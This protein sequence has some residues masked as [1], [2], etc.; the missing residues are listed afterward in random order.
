M[1]STAASLSASVA[2][3]RIEHDG[4]ARL[5]KHALDAAVLLLGNGGFERRQRARLARFEDRLGG[6]EPFRRIAGQEREAAERRVERAAE[7]LLMFTVSRSA[8]GSPGDRLPR[9]GIRKLAVGVLDVDRLLF[10]AEHQLAALQGVQNCRRAR[11]AARG[12]L[13]DARVGLVEIV[14]G[15]MGD[16]VVEACRTAPSRG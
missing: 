9:S 6:I 16:R 13:A 10:G 5:H 14:G 11:T 4:G 12:D 15:K 1:M 3:A 7:P 2:S 8:G